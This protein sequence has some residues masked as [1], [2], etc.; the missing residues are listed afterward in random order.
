MD[1]YKNI[2]RTA[3][4]YIEAN[5]KEDICVDDVARESSYSLFRFTRIFKEL[6]GETPGAYLR[7]RRLEEASSEVLAGRDILEVAFDYR[8]G[9]QEAFTRSFRTYFQTTPGSYRKTGSELGFRRS[10]MTEVEM[11]MDS[12]RISMAVSE[13]VAILKEKSAERYLPIWIGPAEADAI[14]VK[15]LGISVP[16]PLTHDFMRT[17]VESL[18]AS[19]KCVCITKLDND[20]FYAK[21]TL[22]SNDRPLEIDCRP[23]DALALA[24][25]VDAQIFAEEQVLKKA[26]ITGP[27]ESPP[28]HT[29]L[30][31]LKS[32]YA[33]RE[34]T[35]VE[36][37]LL[38]AAL[39]GLSVD[40]LRAI[41]KR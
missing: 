36:Y 39:S 28:E 23:S 29:S 4:G 30:D 1:Y 8:F 25:R 41:V 38:K 19:V 32:R 15:L 9:S 3:I 24:I 6:T 40:K 12:I 37:Q 16:R 33:R 21:A 27:I 5:L 31:V 22:I 35:K 10:N 7:R 13:R 20:T 17:I 18:S 2:I 11:I 26:G 34:I 14:A